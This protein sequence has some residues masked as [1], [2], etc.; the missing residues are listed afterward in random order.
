MRKYVKTIMMRSVN[1]SRRALSSDLRQAYMKGNETMKKIIAFIMIGAALMCGAVSCGNGKKAGSEAV[2]SVVDDGCPQEVKELA[3]SFTGY[4]VN[5]DV[6]NTLSSMYPAELVEGLKSNGIAEEVAG[7]MGAGDHGT[8]KEVKV[9]AAVPLSS[10]AAAG[11]EKYFNTYS[12]FLSS[13][14]KEYTVTEGFVV[15]TDTITD[16]NGKEDVYSEQ[17]TVV[18]VT[19]E[20]WK[21][22]PMSESELVSMV[23][24]GQG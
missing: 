5:G 4:V 7:V 9:S 15:D 19:G 22:I 21:V 14:P 24:E 1:R 16:V 10:D 3:K 18:Q 12:Q 13:S 2:E 11:A 6:D 8:L 23:K 17:L 20:G